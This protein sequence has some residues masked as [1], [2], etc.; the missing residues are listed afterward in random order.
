MTIEIVSDVNFYDPDNLIPYL[1][2][3]EAI[4]RNVTKAM[5][6]FSNPETYSGTGP[7][8]SGSTFKSLTADAALATTASAFPAVAGGMLKFAGLNPKVTLPASFKLP[9]STKKM[10]VILWVKL[11]SSGYQ[12]GSASVTHLLAG[13]AANTTTVCQWGICLTTFQ[14]T[15]LPNRLQFLFPNGAAGAGTLSLSDADSLALCDG[16]LHQVACLW[17][18]ESVSGSRSAEIYIDK[19]KKGS[20]A[21]SAW[22]GTIIVPAASA[23]MGYVAGFQGD[24]PSDGLYM[25][26]HSLWDL[27]GSGKAPGDIIAADWDAAQGYLS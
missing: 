17:D 27:T 14:A 18:G 24:Y 22:D 9:S 21:P 2:N 5:L 8:S 10:L 11:P 23:A 3:D 15:G 19:V 13:Y 20:V 25:G 12:T 16:N 4:I 1:E 6:D 7:I 26:R